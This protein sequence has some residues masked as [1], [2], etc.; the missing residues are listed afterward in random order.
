MRQMI[1]K[2]FIIGII[3]L[4]VL[5]MCSCSAEKKVI[6]E[7]EITQIRSICN[8]ATLE[9]YYH[10]VAKSVK[11]AG[12][13][14]AHW[15]EKERKFWIEYTGVAKVG[16]DMSKVTMEM[17]GTN[18]IISIPDAELMNISVEE[19]TLNEESYIS[20]ADGLN[21]NKITAEDQTAAIENAQKEMEESVK[22]N[23]ALL[24]SAQS[25]AKDLIKNYIDRLGEVSGVEYKITWV[26]EDGEETTKINDEAK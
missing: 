19:S 17:D 13:G 21:S 23:S 20:S 1:K 3:L 7:P 12:E 11:T 25:R 24:L 8:L 5:I 15:G 9:C 10:N 2:I 26:Y 14:I 4:T 18:V 6:N 22:N 16:V